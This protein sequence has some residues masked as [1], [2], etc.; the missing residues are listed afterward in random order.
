MWK[1]C[2]GEV[3][4]LLMWLNLLSNKRCFCGNEIRA[5]VEELAN[6]VANDALFRGQRRPFKLGL[7]QTGIVPV[8]VD[9]DL[10][11]SLLDDLA[12]F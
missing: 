4:L 2:L 7:N 5:K 10:V 8:C 6:D 3:L 9:K 11:G 1:S 12:A